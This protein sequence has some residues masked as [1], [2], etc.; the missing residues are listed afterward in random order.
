MASF[1]LLLLY[2]V[3]LV[4]LFNGDYKLQIFAVLAMCLVQYKDTL[5][6]HLSGIDIV[7]TTIASYYLLRFLLFKENKKYIVVSFILFA[8]GINN[9]YTILL[10]F[11]PLIGL[12]LWNKQLT[13]DKKSWLLIIAAFL[14]I[15]GPNL[16]W[17]IKHDFMFL[18][19]VSH[20]QTSH[21]KGFSRGTLLFE[22]IFSNGFG[23][24]IIIIGFWDM[25]KRGVTTK[26][27]AL[28][29]LCAVI[30]VVATNGKN[31]YCHNFQPLLFVFGVIKINTFFSVQYKKYLAMVFILLFFIPQ[32]LCV[33]FILPPRLLFEYCE[34][35]RRNIKADIFMHKADDKR[36]SKNILPKMHSNMVGWHSL[37]KEISN[38]YKTKGAGAAYIFCQNYGQAAAIMVIG[39]DYGL[40]EP[41]CLHDNFF[42]WGCEEKIIEPSTLFIVS[43]YGFSKEI[44]SLFKIKEDMPV[45]KDDF[46][47]EDITSIYKF[48]SPNGSFPDYWKF[49]ISKVDNPSK[50]YG[51]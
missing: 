43:K 47:Q 5:M 38:D 21:F 12:L 26:L 46:A 4:R 8:I 6:Y 10:F 48:T 33:S 15:I 16:L 50:G 18:K 20:I 28:A 19:Y 7:I 27:F 13:I 22:T 40:P 23:S 30:L 2:V 42:Y 1:F 41:L 34:F 37:I 29:A 35:L 31:H 17:Q 32:F 45:F 44:N 36:N 14:V 51:L 3:K 11:I 24:I 9:K 49:I 39:K 25:I